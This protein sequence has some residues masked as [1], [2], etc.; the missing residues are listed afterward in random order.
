MKNVPKVRKGLAGGG[1]TGSILVWLKEG[2]EGGKMEMDREGGLARAHGVKALES[3]IRK[4][5]PVRGCRWEMARSGWGRGYR[6]GQ[7]L[8]RVLNGTRRQEG[9]SG[10]S[11]LL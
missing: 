3:C 6:L 1:I 5:K 8:M 7:R 10:N 2:R 11:P 9:D 4:E